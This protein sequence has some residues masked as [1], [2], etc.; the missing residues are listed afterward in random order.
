MKQPAGPYNHNLGFPRND[1]T[2]DEPRIPWTT[3]TAG[4]PDLRMNRW[5]GAIDQHLTY[6]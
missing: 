3:Q 4:V 2:L 5:P 1:P 6:S